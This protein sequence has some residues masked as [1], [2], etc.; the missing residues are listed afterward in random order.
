MIEFQF[1]H[2]FTKAKAPLG[3][4][5]NHSKN[6]FLSA[7]KNLT[8]MQNNYLARKTRQFKGLC[9]KIGK[10]WD[11]FS[12]QEREN[13]LGRFRRLYRNLQTAFARPQLRKMMGA[14]AL[15]LMGMGNVQGQ[16]FKAP[17]QDTI[18]F[19][20]Q[21]TLGN[22]HTK[23]V[24]VD[25]DGDGD[26]DCFV[27]SL[28]GN[29]Y[30]FVN[31]GTAS[32]PSFQLSGGATPTANPF[33]LS[34][35]S[36]L[37]PSGGTFPGFGD[38]D[39]DGDYDA[40]AGQTYGSFYYFE[41]TGSAS[42]PT[43]A[44]Y[45]VDTFGLAPVTDALGFG[46]IEPELVDLDNDGDLDLVAGDYAGHFFYYENTGDSLNPSFAAVVQDTFGITGLSGNYP[47]STPSFIDFDG[48]GDLDMFSGSSTGDLHYFENTGTSSSP[49]FDTPQINPFGFLRPSSSS[50]IVSTA[51]ADLNNDG[52]IDLLLGSSTGSFYYYEGDSVLTTTPPPP[53]N[54]EENIT[55]PLFRTYPNPVSNQLILEFSQAANYQI[56]VTDITGREVYNEFIQADNNL[57][58]S[59]QAWPAGLYLLQV[60]D[61]QGNVSTQKVVKE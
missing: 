46:T 11:S 50:M 40:I 55:V 57:Q 13:L 56:L 38:L 5:P 4:K 26:L 14:A 53:L 39:G 21:L 16:Y 6:I 61:E 3:G 20:G 22:G 2:G 43:F 34:D 15:V 52:R 60:R 31:N 23:P 1:V 30:Y 47:Q 32:I 8:I 28:S 48:D 9:K 7:I 54:L 24:F 49:S 19:T 59:T 25:I 10:R 29:F 51:L 42:A 17:A 41:N 33:G 37:S 58:L 27:G 45:A 35:L 36:A 18:G 12:S 44:A